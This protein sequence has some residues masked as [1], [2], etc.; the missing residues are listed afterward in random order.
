M[1]TLPANRTTARWSHPVLV[2]YVVVML[3]MFLL[4]MP[5][6]P[7]VEASHLDK[8]VHF[9]IFA[10]FA[11][12]FRMDRRGTAWRTLFIAAAFAGAIELV[13]SMLPYR[14]GDWWDFVAGAAGAGLGTIL[15]PW[16]E[17]RAGAATPP[18]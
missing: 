2:C 8:L 6:A 17:R 3:A 13:Q 12:L 10:V 4:P 11:L 9:G 18:R 16:I 7:L 5:A 15:Q 14:D 1:P